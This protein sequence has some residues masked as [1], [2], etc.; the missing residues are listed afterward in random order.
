MTLPLL[1]TRATRRPSCAGCAWCDL[2]EYL[3]EYPPRQFSRSSR[4]VL[5]ANS[6]GEFSRRISGAGARAFLGGASRPLHGRALVRRKVGRLL[7][8]AEIFAEI[9]VRCPSL[10]RISAEITARFSTRTQDTQAGSRASRHKHQAQEAPRQAQGARSRRDRDEMAT[11]SVPPD[12]S[13]RVAISVITI[14]IRRI[15][16][17]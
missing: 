3:G 14:A 15:S 6:L 2:G 17:R 8:M 13:A 4:R 1:I 16:T 7:Y 5:S 12:A 10:H 11:R 9:T